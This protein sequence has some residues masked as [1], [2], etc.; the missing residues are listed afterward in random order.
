[1]SS[2]HHNGGTRCVTALFWLSVLGSAF[3]QFSNHLKPM[4][5]APFAAPIPDVMDVL[6][7]AGGGGGGAAYGG[8]G[9]AGGLLYSAAHS[10]TPKSYSITV[11]TGGAGGAAANTD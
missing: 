2:A 1:M 5:G 4:G 6:V 3:G 7:V 10:V 11:G 9:G 8:G